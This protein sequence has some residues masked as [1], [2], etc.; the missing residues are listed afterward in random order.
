MFVLDCSVTMS[1][2]FEEESENSAY[3]D[4]VLERLKVEDA[5]VPRLWHLEVLNV[6]LA[7]ERRRR[8]T[9]TDS[10]RFLEYLSLLPITTDPM[11]VTIQD[12][13]V[14]GLARKYQ[15]S[16]YDTAYLALA[17][18]EEL[19]IATQDRGLAAAAKALGVWLDC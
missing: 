8:V 11:P 7:S 5:L 16:S 18:G 1:W 12:R 13:E 3:A 14:L 10:D 4:K 6:L 9:P 19:K 2:F 17:V 15:L